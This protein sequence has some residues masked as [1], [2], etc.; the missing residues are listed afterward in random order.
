MYIPTEIPFANI[1]AWLF[2]L[3]GTLMDTDDQAVE[4]LAR[5]IRFLGTE[6]AY[7][8]ARRMVMFSETPMNGMLTMLDVV[9]LDAVLFGIRRRLKG[10]IP[11]SFRIIEGVIPLLQ[12]LAKDHPLAVVSTRAEAD[13]VAFLNQHKLETFFK[14]IVGQHHTWRLKPHP[15]PVLYAAQK[16]GVPPQSCVMVGDTPVDILSARRAD[17]WA[18]GVLCGFGEEAELWRAGAHRVVKSTGDLLEI[19]KKDSK[20]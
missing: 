3:D 1:K 8:I 7:K 17:A 13:A 14:L 18:I 9:G 16:L 2:D 11:P 10:P 6:R 15:E 20:S 12:H 5:R 19:I 4:S